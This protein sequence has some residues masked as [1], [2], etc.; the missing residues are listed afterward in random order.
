MKSENRQD[1]KQRTKAFALRII[2]LY[3]AL[4]KSPEAQ[5]LGKQ[6][7]RS[8]TSVGAHYHEACRAKS[9][10][11]FVSKVEGGLQELDETIYWLELL[12]EANIFTEE[13]LK[14]LHQE[15]EELISMFVTIVKNVK[16]RSKTIPAKGS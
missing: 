14:P 15:A 11:D 1:L 5:V 6:I 10:A 8:G 2:R 7:L 16:V 3:T 4:P 9:D 12:G 13:R